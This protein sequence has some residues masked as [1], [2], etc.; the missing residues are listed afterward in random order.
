MDAKSRSGRL[1]SSLRGWRLALRLGPAL[2][3]HPPDILQTYPNLVRHPDVE[4]VD[5]GWFYKGGLYP[6]YLHMGGASHQIASVALEYCVGRGADV[7]AGLWPLPGATPVDIWRG[8]GAQRSLDD[9]EA[10]ELDFVF[11]SHCL[12]HIDDWRGAL[13]SWTELVRPGG[14]VFLY[15][16]HPECA[17][18]EPGSAFVGDAHVWAPSPPV[19]KEAL[20]D[21][22]FAI[23]AFDDGPDHYMSFYVCAKKTLAPTAA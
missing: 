4:R 21:L 11:S 10:G 22:G 20:E 9:F 2:R 1:V 14:A 6:D 3:S 16:P 15:L 12:E 8:P 19:I 23:D 7:G 17:I 5:G 13:K 18:W